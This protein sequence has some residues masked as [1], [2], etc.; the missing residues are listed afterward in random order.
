MARNKTRFLTIVLLFSMVA[1]M[2]DAGY[3]V[4]AAHTASLDAGYSAT[5]VTFKLEDYVEQEPGYIFIYKTVNNYG[6]GY[7]WYT[8]QEA[9][10]RLQIEEDREWCGH[11]VRPWRFTK[12]HIN[13]YWT[14][15]TWSHSWAG[16]PNLDL[17]LRWMLASPN[18]NQNVIPNFNNYLW[19][20]GDKR[21][22]RQNAEDIGIPRSVTSYGIAGGNIPAYNLGPK[23]SITN[24]YN[25]QGSNSFYQSYGPSA[26]PNPWVNQGT[27]VS[28]NNQWVLRIRHMGAVTVD[29]TTY[30]DVIRLDFYE[31]NITGS[32]GGSNPGFLRESWYYAKGV[33][34][35]Q[36]LI[37]HFNNYGGMQSIVAPSCNISNLSDIYQEAPTGDCLS[38]TIQSPAQKITLQ[39]YYHNP[40]FHVTLNGNS[41]SSTCVGTHGSVEYTIREGLAPPFVEA[42]R[43]TGYLEV[44]SGGAIAKW[45]WVE[46]GKVTVD[47]NGSLP[48]GT[49][50]ARFRVW[51]PNELD[52]NETNLQDAN[53]P[54]SNWVTVQ[55]S[56]NC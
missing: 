25:A 31:G 45:R 5:N 17:N 39:E 36:I 10:T 24:A 9:T 11:L 40:R 20:V 16:N 2:F 38:A 15:F 37:K 12:D 13:G 23:A 22:N 7:P 47:L 26:C 29:S 48:A 55:V 52:S 28:P 56:S 18:Y 53:P 4:P 33:G 51:V 1:V 43:F 35:V 27:G 6:M 30:S 44:Q 49:Y 21:Y 32:L 42:P 34:L 46:D 54:W 14:P 3:N 19:G 8:P 50:T 41:L